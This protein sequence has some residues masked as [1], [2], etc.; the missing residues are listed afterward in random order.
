MQQAEC[1]HSATAIPASPGKTPDFTGKLSMP[2]RRS[3]FGLGAALVAVSAAP[4]RAS[5]RAWEGKPWTDADAAWRGC[6]TA[7]RAAEAASGDASEAAW[8]AADAARA[9]MP[10]DPAQLSPAMY[11]GDARDLRGRAL[12]QYLRSCMAAPI[13]AWKRDRIARDAVA[14][15]TWQ[16]ACATIRDGHDLARLEAR[17]DAAWERFDTARTTLFETRPP[18]IEAAIEKIAIMRETDACV[19]PLA[20]IAADLKGC[21]I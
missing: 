20:I 12:R 1:A 18:S 2:S 13:V 14:I 15:E 6:V 17:N 19:D 9:A 16:D 21:S 3:L 4:A 7:Y 5:G 8:D 11:G 10:A